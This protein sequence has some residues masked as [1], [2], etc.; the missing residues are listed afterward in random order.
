MAELGDSQCPAPSY[1]HVTVG[2]NLGVSCGIGVLL[3]G[4]GVLAEQLGPHP[5]F[6]HLQHD[7]PGLFYRFRGSV[8][9]DQAAVIEDR[10]GTV[11]QSSGIVLEGEVGTFLHLEVAFL[12]PRRQMISPVV[13]SI[14]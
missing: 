7:R 3:V 1:E 13:R 4:M 12:A 2:Q 8:L 11:G 9:E 14:L 6:V 5:F 10:D